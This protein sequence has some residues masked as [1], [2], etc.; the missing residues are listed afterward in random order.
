[1]ES[2][3]TWS[4]GPPPELRALKGLRGVAGTTIGLAQLQ[5]LLSVG[6]ST[7][8]MWRPSVDLFFCPSGFTLSP[9]YRRNEF[10]FSRDLIT[11]IARI[12]PLYARPA[13]I[14]S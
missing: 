2:G 12:C 11:R 14:V 5:R 4:S 7:F 3:E 10:Q 1:M 9:V 6:P 8:F 13:P